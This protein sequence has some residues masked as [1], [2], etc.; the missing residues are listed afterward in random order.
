MSSTSSSSWKASP[1]SPPELQQRR[2]PARRAGARRSRRRTRT[3][4]PSSAGSAPGSARRE[5]EVER[6]A[7]LRQLAR[8]ASDDRGRATSSATW[9]PAPRRTRRARRTRARTSRSPTAVA[10]SRP[11]CATTVGRP[12]RS[13]AASST[14]SWTSVAMWTSS[15]AV[16]ARNGLLARVTGRRRAG[17]A[18]AA[19]ACR[20]A[21]RVAPASARQRLAVAADELAEPLLDGGHPAGQ[22]RLRGVEHHA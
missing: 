6:V 1:I 18:A 22:P 4:A 10:R 5:R 2:R 11:E 20:P 8:R 16:A 7:A 13:G 17:R 12:R 14:S 15:I 19:A 3:A 9:P 21:A